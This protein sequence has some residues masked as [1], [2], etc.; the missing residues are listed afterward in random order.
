MLVHT[1]TVVHAQTLVQNPVNLVKHMFQLLIEIYNI[2]TIY[3]ITAIKC[4][5]RIF[6]QFAIFYL[7]YSFEQYCGTVT[8]QQKSYQESFINDITQLGG[9]VILT[10]VPLG[11]KM[12]VKQPFK[13]V[14]RGRGSIFGQIC[15]TSFINASF[16]FVN[17]FIILTNK[18]YF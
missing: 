13:F 3:I 1:Q 8:N 15:V 16:S 17:F 12:Q 6:R 7:N 11:I 18:K 10:F 5:K 4:S 9:G 2:Q 14:K